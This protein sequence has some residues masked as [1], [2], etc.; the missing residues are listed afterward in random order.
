MILSN[1]AILK[2]GSSLNDIYYLLGNSYER[3]EN[4]ENAA[5]CY[6]KAIDIKPD[7]SAY[8]RDYAIAM[9]YTGNMEEAEKALETAR[10]NGLDSIDIDYV[11]GEISYNNGDYSGAK[12][13]FADCIQK[14]DDD[15]LRMRAYIMECKCIDGQ[16]DGVSGSDEKIQILEKA[17]KELPKEYNIGILEQLA[18]TYSDLGNDTSDM[19]YYQEAAK[20]F[21]QI[22][23]QG[24]GTYDT[25]YNLSVLYQNMQQ[26][27]QEETVLNQMLE[28]YGDNYKTYK[29][30]AYLEVAKQSQ[31]DNEGRDYTKF[32]EY[33]LK[34]KELYQSQPDNN[35]NDMEM[36]NLQDLYEQA[37]A[38]GW[39]SAS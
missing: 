18:Q 9:A 32:Q 26:Y 5:E 36:D 20:V 37:V 33:Y 2:S 8:Y 17:R 14:T 4:Y 11:E 31:A 27:D 29:A 35:A 15:Y 24:M 22:Q 34:A 13:I 3:M 19:S 21:E 10:E 28:K 39:M 7:N 16:D 12:D 23:S 38:N 25:D 30:L 6:K 1:D